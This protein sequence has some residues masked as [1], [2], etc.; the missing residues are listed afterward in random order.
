MV[1]AYLWVYKQGLYSLFWKQRI[2][3]E[4]PSCLVLIC[5]EESAPQ[6]VIEIGNT[7]IQIHQ[8]WDWWAQSLYE[9]GHL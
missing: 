2:N 1:W 7:N 8:D 9:T 5:Q 3:K 4:N 6:K